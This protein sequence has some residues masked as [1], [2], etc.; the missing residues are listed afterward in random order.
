MNLDSRAKAVWDAETIVRAIERT[1][2]G[3]AKLAY[4]KVCR[5]KNYVRVFGP[6]TD[7]KRMAPCIIVELYN[8]T[9]ATNVFEVAKYLEF[10]ERPR[11]KTIR[12]HALGASSGSLGKFGGADWGLDAEHASEQFDTPSV[13][14]R[15]LVA[16]MSR[17]KSW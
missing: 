11:D 13:Y 10:H 3:S 7:V 17:C 9:V 4:L 2:P 8:G 1:K 6:Q 16:A 5:T 15:E 12:E 14:A